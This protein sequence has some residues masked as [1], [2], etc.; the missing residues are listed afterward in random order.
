MNLELVEQ[1][2]TLGKSTLEKDRIIRGELTKTKEQFFPK[3]V[4]KEL[5]FVTKPNKKSVVIAACLMA[6]FLVIAIILAVGAVS[7]YSRVGKISDIIDNPGEKYEAWL[8]SFSNYSYF[9]ELEDG[10]AEVEADWKSRGVDVDWKYV[11]T[12]QQKRIQGAVSSDNYDK[13][14]MKSLEEDVDDCFTE[15]APMT[16]FAIVLII[17]TIVFAVKLKNRCKKLREETKRFVETTAKNAPLIKYN[18]EELPKLIK[19]WEEKLPEMQVEYERYINSL[20]VKVTQLDEEISKYEHLLP[21]KYHHFAEDIAVYI[22]GGFT[23][24]IDGA[25][26]LF[27]EKMKNEMAMREAARRRYT[28]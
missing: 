26:M 9:N 25:I 19:E 10:W 14:L 24:S 2:K 15:A 21:S 27:E 13:Q 23:C 6:S 22:G 16:F 12:V 18:E 7:C 8:E 4:E 1:L 28:W 3:P 17:P 11:L 5:F 20:K